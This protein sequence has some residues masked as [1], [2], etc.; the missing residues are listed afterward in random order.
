MR[1]FKD[2]DQQRAFERSGFVTARLLSAD[3]AAALLKEIRGLRPADPGQEENRLR[4]GFYASFADG[5]LARRRQVY[6]ILRDAL[7]APLARI[8]DNYRITTGTLLEK[9]PKAGYFE[10]HCDWT[11]SS[12]LLDVNVG[13]WCPL[14]DTDNVNGTLHVLPGSQKLMPHIAAP[15][16]AFY[17]E[18][19]RHVLR[20][21]SLSFPLR[22]GEAV[23][24]EG[25]MP[26]WSPINNSGAERSAANLMCLPASAI[27][28]FFKRSSPDDPQRFEIFDMRGDGFYAHSLADFNAGNL[29]AP[30]LGEV[31]VQ[32]R[33]V[34]RL[35]FE[36]R[37]AAARA[38]LRLAPGSQPGWARKPAFATRG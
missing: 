22:A 37:Y 26:H 15:H 24:Y 27:P 3:D 9:P 28:A 14:I 35:E 6:R 17:G 7:A 31:V 4:T 33:I 8:L 29:H 2:D 32:N 20:K 11:T 5:D 1:T 38:R 16:A 12:S 19:Y 18:H 34:P 23:I 10:L 25:S 13:C 36:A 30:S 21:K